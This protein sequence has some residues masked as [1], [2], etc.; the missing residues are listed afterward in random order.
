VESAVESA[1]PADGES[2]EEGNVEGGNVEGMDGA[3]GRA[4][5]INTRV[6]G[7]AYRIPK[8]KFDSMSK[9]MGDLLQEEGSNS[10]A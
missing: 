7:W 4:A 1:P 3:A 9:R 2:A 5:E 6:S 8:Y 10:G